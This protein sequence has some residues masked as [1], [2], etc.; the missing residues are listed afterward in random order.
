MGGSILALFAGS[1]ERAAVNIV[2]GSDTMPTVGPLRSLR[3]GL[4]ASV[5]LLHPLPRKRQKK[6][7]TMRGKE[8]ER[9][10]GRAT[11][12]LGGTNIVGGQ[13]KQR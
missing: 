13:E 5:G 12:R 2:S 7:K 1:P 9:E 11:G 4:P 8:R 3:H 10:K 6:K